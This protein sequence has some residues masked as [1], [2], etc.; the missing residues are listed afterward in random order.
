[1][2]R[3]SMKRASS[4]PLASFSP[5]LGHLLQQFWGE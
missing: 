5:T 1:M 3:K 2:N 4:D